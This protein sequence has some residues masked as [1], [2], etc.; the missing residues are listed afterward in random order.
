M[1]KHRYLWQDLDRAAD[2]IVAQLAQDEWCPEHI[3]GIGRGGLPLAVTISHR[4]NRPMTSLDVSLRDGG[5]TESNLWLAEWAF[6]YNYP[7]QTGI[8]PSRWDP[9]LRKKMLIVDGINDSG[10]TFQWIVQDWQ[11]GCLPDEQY[12]WDAVW[13]KTVRFATMTNNVNSDFEVDYTW[14]EL[15][16]SEND[17]WLV[18]PWENG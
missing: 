15:D 16:K 18:Y 5:E 4:L 8:S 3:V 9:S 11:S 6:G 2:C 13:H 10:A 1:T 12:A 14:D 17:V 7:E